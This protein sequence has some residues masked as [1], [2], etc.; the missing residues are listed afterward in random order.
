[1]FFSPSKALGMLRFQ[2]V[3]RTSKTLLMLRFQR[4]QD[5]A[6][7]WW[8]KELAKVLFPAR[9]KSWKKRM[10]HTTKW[11]RKE[12]EIQEETWDNGGWHTMCRPLVA[13]SWKGIA[14]VSSRQRQTWNAEKLM[15]YESYVWVFVWRSNLG[16]HAN[17][18]KEL[19]KIMWLGTKRA[20]KW[21]YCLLLTEMETGR[22]KNKKPANTNAVRNEHACAKTHSE[23]LLSF[24]Q[25]AQSAVKDAKF[26]HGEMPEST[27][28]P[29]ANIVTL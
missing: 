21:K 24:S 27:N 28:N 29:R 6:S 7:F 20:S 22:V 13:K 5:S 12:G 16:N 26:E 18:T 2:H 17:L 15:S 11:V 4:L 25:K 1:M 3:L 14:S 10:S 19:G 9:T 8:C 23:T